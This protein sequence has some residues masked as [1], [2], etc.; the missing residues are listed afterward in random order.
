MFVLSKWY[1]DCV[2]DEGA[3]FVGYWAR[4]RWGLLRVPYA[5]TLYKPPCDA[6]RE[7]YFIRPCAAP[8]RQ[9]GELRWDCGRLGLRAVWTAGDP[10]IHRA[11]LETAEGSITWHCH[12]PRARARIELAGAGRLSG[13]GY[14]EQLTMSMKPWRLPFEELRWGRYLSAEDTVTWIELR[15][16]ESRQWVFHNGAEQRGATIR[17]GIGTGIGTGRIALPGDHGIVELHDAVVLREGRLASRAL[18]AI[19]AARV[20]LPG[21]IKNAYETKWVARGTLTAGARSSSGW[22]IHEVVRLR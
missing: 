19:P 4:M 20:W 9:D 5:A 3:A 22:A 21:G 7:R 13:L 14:A 15:G 11:L 6:T 8:N 17:T 16:R 10:A 12:S 1:C 2:S 18:R